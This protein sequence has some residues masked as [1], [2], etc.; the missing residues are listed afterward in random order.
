MLHK[1]FLPQK[2]TFRR[3]PDGE[4]V[5]VFGVSRGKEGKE[6]LITKG[7]KGEEGRRGGEGG[8][9]VKI[10]WEEEEEGEEKKKKGEGKKEVC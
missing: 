6:G 10:N 2:V 4:G 3:V 1:P 5:T 9:S 8:Y 7:L